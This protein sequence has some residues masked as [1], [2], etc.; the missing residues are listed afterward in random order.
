MRPHRLPLAFGLLALA[1]AVTASRA[2]ADN[3]RK[4]YVVPYA[5]QCTYGY[6]TL[7]KDAS[8]ANLSAVFNACGRAQNVAVSC[9]TSSDLRLHAV[10]LG[11]LYQDVAQQAEIALFA[12]QFAVASALLREKLQ[13]LD[14]V[15][16]D[17]KRG[18]PTVAHERAAT[19]T[20]LADAGA[21]LCTQTA[22]ST[23][24]EQ[25]ALAHGRKY[26]ELAALLRRKSGDYAACARRAPTLSKRAYLEYVDLVALEESGRAAQAAGNKR[27][28]DATYH[29]CLANAQRISRYARPPV[30]TYLIA[31]SALCSGRMNGRYAVDQPAPLD[32]RDTK[33]F[34]PL[35]LPKR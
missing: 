16:H 11:A 22:M 13:I 20:D 31:V 35:V 25:S 15:A 29:D 5:E 3:C 32:A 2:R 4:E 21:G 7:K 6:R 33:G 17:A 10:A 8:P 30:T 1:L 12:Q 18:D 24:S 28:A 34:R 14:I 26:A 19:K 9:V 23:T 27:D